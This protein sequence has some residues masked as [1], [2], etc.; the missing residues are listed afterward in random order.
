M[1]PSANALLKCTRCKKTPDGADWAA[2]DAQGTAI[3]TACARCWKADLHF[4][5]ADGIEW[6][7]W[8]QQCSEDPAQ[9]S[10][11][12]VA[13]SVLVDKFPCPWTPEEVKGDE[14]CELTITRPFIGIARSDFRDLAGCEPSNCFV[15]ETYL[16]NEHFQTYKG[17]LLHH[18]YR[19]WLEYNLTWRVGVSRERFHL[20]RTHHAVPE[21][22]AEAMDA[23]RQNHDTSF[24]VT[25]LRNC[26][27]TP[28]LLEERVCKKF[29]LCGALRRM[30]AATLQARRTQV[31]V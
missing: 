13:A 25:K 30:L 15:P 4:H 2:F 31:L 6:S 21:A 18:P 27:M 9:N 11:V 8:C 17:V 16:K 26:T 3:S 23:A 12:E 20:D 29:F 24:L 14:G 10:R 7:C 22:A 28:T 5:V 1:P 19:P